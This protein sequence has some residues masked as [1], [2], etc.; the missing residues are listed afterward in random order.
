SSRSRPWWSARRKSHEEQHRPCCRTDDENRGH[1]H[2]RTSGR[3]VHRL[4][5]HTVFD[6]EGTVL[7]SGHDHLPVPFPQVPAHSEATSRTDDPLSVLEFD[8][9][10]SEDPGYTPS[11]S[12]E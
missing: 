2:L 6:G 8:G 7:G 11:H 9:L 1:Q 10:P 4:C 12:W 5:V 3:G